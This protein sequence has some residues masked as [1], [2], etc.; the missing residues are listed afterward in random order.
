[1][2]MKDK[3]STEGKT[4]KSENVWTVKKSEVGLSIMKGNVA[5]A[6]MVFQLDDSELIKAHAICDA[7]NALE[8]QV[9]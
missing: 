7:M 3:F 1:M 5:I 9:S 8:L 4:M 6:N 2:C